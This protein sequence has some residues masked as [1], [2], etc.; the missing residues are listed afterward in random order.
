[1]ATQSLADLPGEAAYYCDPADVGSIRQAVLFAHRNHEFD[2]HN[3]FEVQRRCV[4]QFRW[5][6]VAE[7]TLSAYQ[8]ALAARTVLETAER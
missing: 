5:T 1:M 6:R 3:R 2:Q 4:E 8:A 7:Q